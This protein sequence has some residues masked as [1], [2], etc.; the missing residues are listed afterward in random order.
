MRFAFYAVFLR[1]LRRH[2]ELSGFK[3][4]KVQGEVSCLIKM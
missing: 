4:G 3:F 1:K 2:G